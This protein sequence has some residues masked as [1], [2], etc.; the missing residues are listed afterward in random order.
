MKEIFNNYFDNRE[1]S[2]LKFNERV[3]EEAEDSSLP[4]MER[5]NFVS[6]FCSNLDEF[7]MVRAGT[8]H[9]QTLLKDGKKDNKTGL[10]PSEQ[11]TKIARRTAELLPRKENAYRKIIEGLKEYGV[12]QVYPD[13]P[14]NGEEAQWIEKYFTKEILPLLSP[15]VVDKTHPLPFLKNKEL[16]AGIALKPHGGGKHIV[17]G[18]VPLTVSD[19]FK[20]IVFLPCEKGKIRFM[21]ME[22]LIINFVDKVFPNFEVCDRNIFRITRNA[23]IDVDE[24][25]FDHDVDFRDVMEE[26][27]KKRKK[28]A[29]IRIEL[30]ARSSTIDK[31]LL[32]RK[33]G[34]EMSSDFIFVQNCPLDF[35]FAGEIR[36]R[37]TDKPELFFDTRT[38]QQPVMVKKSRSMIEQA[39]KGDMLLFY[40]Y[41]SFGAFIRLLDEAAADPTVVSIKITLYRVARDSKIVNTLIRAAENGKD[42]LALVELRARFDEENNIGWAKR[43]SDAGVTVIYGLDG[44]KVHSKLLLITRRI[45]NEIKYVTQVGTGNYNERTSR[46]YTDLTLITSDKEFGTDASLIFNNLSVGVAVESSSTLWVA[47]NC[48]KS[49]VVEMIDREITYGKEGYIGIKMNS[50]TDIDII[51]KLVEASRRG[52]KVELI[53]RGICCLVAGIPGF[54]DNV[55]VVSIVGRFLEHSRIYIFGKNERRRLYIS[56][57]D[58]MTRNTERRVEVAAPIKNKAIQTKLLAIFDAMLRDNVKARI[59]LPDGTYVHKERKEGEPSL[60]SQKFFY[61]QAYGN[62]EAAAKNENDAKSGN[63]LS[64]GNFAAAEERAVNKAKT[65]VKVRRISKK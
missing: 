3:L 16:Y 62:A 52:V 49:R 27:I 9:D 5:L 36:D 41:E 33:L 10:T 31:E 45:G 11:L 25:L 4:L 29:P 55:T 28:L 64:G 38:P 39:D 7:F 46:L 63:D 14:I 44:L 22:D 61:E 65:V 42:V 34:L 54:T 43:L 35:G 6:I 56:S 13:N 20:R 30:F 37:L 47:P 53:I 51:Q 17:L 60:D 15:T 57:A 32:A 1:L 21:L 24:A 48:L 23:D 18:V 8:L 2:W 50:L 58:F 26:L 40:P 19:V 12:E 59:Q